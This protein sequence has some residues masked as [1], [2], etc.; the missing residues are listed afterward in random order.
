MNKITK[1]KKPK[2][3]ATKQSIFSILVFTKIKIKINKIVI[4]FF[5]RIRI[6]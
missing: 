6:I 4:L 3:M 1:K 2:R 5:F